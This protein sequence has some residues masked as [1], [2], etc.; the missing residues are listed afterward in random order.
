MNFVAKESKDVKIKH[1]T[2]DVTVLLT[3]NFIIKH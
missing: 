1:V 3:I 2:V